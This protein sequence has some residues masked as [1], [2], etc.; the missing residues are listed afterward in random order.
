MS[1]F[2]N[3]ADL[4]CAMLGVP[5]DQGYFLI[6]GLKVDEIL[7]LLKQVWVVVQ[8][9]Q[10]DFGGFD[11]D[12]GGQIL[13]YAGVCGGCHHSSFINMATLCIEPP[14]V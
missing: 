14:T 9:V 1:M 10:Y 13:S 3:L 5:A 8:V 4:Y 12:G 2:E 6:H 7:D 11:Q